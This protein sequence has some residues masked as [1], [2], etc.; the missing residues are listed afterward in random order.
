MGSKSKIPS[1][2]ALIFRHPLRGLENFLHLQ[3]VSKSAPRLRDGTFF[4][5]IC[6]G[7]N[8]PFFTASIAQLVELLIC[9]QQVGGSSPSAG[10]TPGIF[11]LTFWLQSLGRYRSG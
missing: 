7:G 5:R 1:A 9:N 4:K 6:K 3:S 8:F 11:F 10:S 2:I